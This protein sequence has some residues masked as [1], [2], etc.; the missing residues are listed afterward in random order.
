MFESDNQYRQSLVS[1]FGGRLALTAAYERVRIGAAE[2]KMETKWKHR[3]IDRLG[4]Q[5]KYLTRMVARGGIEPPTRGFS[6]LQLL[7]PA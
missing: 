4:D 6:A 5:R 1:L 2:T 7:H 3:H